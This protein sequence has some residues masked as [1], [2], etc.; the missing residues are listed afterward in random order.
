METYSAL[1]FQGSIASSVLHWHCIYLLHSLMGRRN[2]HFHKIKIKNSFHFVYVCAHVCGYPQTPE[3]ST[4]S[5]VIDFTEVVSHQTWVLRTQF[6]WQVPWEPL[7]AEGPLTSQVC[8][9]LIFGQI[10]YYEFQSLV[11]LLTFNFG[12]PF[13]VSF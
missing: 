6:S 4:G 3:E 1:E 9:I 2:T 10:I 11:Y 5:L 7:T 8:Y 12:F 13:M